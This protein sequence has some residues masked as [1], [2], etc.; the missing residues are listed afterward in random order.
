MPTLSDVRDRCRADLADASSDTWSDDALDRHIQH[1]LAELS[2]AIPQELTATLETTAGSRDLSLV[3][4]T[5]LIEV[6]SVEYPLGQFPPS[7][8]GFS[9]W[10]STISL[11]TEAAPTGEDAKLYYTA[12]HTLDHDGSTLPDPLVD[13]LV[14][15]ATAYAALEQAAATT[16]ALTVDP[17]ASERYAAWARARLTA[18]RQLLHTYGRKNRLRARRMYVPA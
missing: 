16:N 7:F 12:A 11:H 10:G 8:V 9:S 15:G 1:A 13:I 5:G 2:L 18:F 17:A 6:E 4:L 3:S 14:T